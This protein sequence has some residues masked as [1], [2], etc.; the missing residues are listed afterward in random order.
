MQDRGYELPRTPLLGTSVNK[1]EKG[2]TEANILGP[3]AHLGYFG[4]AKRG[5]Q[6]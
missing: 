2:G 4:A 1:D 3:L 6:L 5:K